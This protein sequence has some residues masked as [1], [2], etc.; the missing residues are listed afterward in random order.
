VP[1]P[2]KQGGP[3]D[4]L[5]H[6]K[7]AFDAKKTFRKA[8]LGMMA[9]K[10]MSTLANHVSSERALLFKYKEESEREDMETANIL[11]H[12]N[13]RHPDSAHPEQAQMKK[14]DDISNPEPPVQEFANSSLEDGK[15]KDV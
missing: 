11:H 15:T 1:D 13:E 4:L 9:M 7:K 8:V 14:V 2:D 3:T 10:R 6:V 12:H 5:P